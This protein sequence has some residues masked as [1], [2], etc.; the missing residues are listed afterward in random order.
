MARVGSLE[1]TGRERSIIAQG[2]S[3]DDPMGVFLR[4]AGQFKSFALAVPRV[5]RRIGNS[6]PEFQGRKLL[7][8]FRNIGDASLLAATMTEVTLLSAVGMMAKD[9]MKGKDRDIDAKFLAEAFATGAMPL[10]VSYTLDALRGEYDGYGR[11]ILKDLAGPT[12]GQTDDVVALISGAARMDSKVGIKALRL[13]ESNTPG[14]NLPF[15][16]AALNK[17]FLT[18]LHE[19]LNPGYELRLRQRAMHEGTDFLFNPF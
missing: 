9:A 5:L 12:F 13:I 6:N 17:L 3:P 14:I 18:D 2:F 8:G 19:A 15:A 16:K 10:S 7:D 4:L 11:S 1:A